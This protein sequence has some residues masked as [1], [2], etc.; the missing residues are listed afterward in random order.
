MTEEMTVKLTCVQFA[1]D[2]MK[3]QNNPV[4]PGDITAVSN[5]IYQYITNTSTKQ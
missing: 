2:L 5:E 3:A 1:I 4:A